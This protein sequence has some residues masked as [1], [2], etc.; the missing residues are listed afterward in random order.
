MHE[1]LI[2]I[3]NSLDH[4]NSF[5]DLAFALRGTH[6]STA[7]LCRTNAECLRVS[8]RLF[9]EGVDHRLQQEATE[10]VLPAWLAE[11]FDGVD[12]KRWSACAWR[13]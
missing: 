4:I 12:R 13:D 2:E 3:L 1:P 10:R 7:V 9:E 6:E 5:D 8:Q 11:L